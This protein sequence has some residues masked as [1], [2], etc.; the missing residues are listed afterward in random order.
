MNLRIILMEKIDLKQEMLEDLLCEAREEELREIDMR[1]DF[2]SFIT[3][4]NGIEIVKSIESLIRVA[5]SYG[6]SRDDIIEYITE[7]V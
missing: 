1:N 5:D 6:Y 3:Y 4:S 2:D 7:N